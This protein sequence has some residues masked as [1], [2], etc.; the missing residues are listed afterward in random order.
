[1]SYLAELPAERRTFAVGSFPELQINADDYLERPPGEEAIE[2]FALREIAVLGD[3]APAAIQQLYG[4]I[5][6]NKH[7]RIQ[8]RAKAIT[9]A[10]RTR[11]NME[12]Q[13]GLQSVGARERFRRDFLA[14]K[15]DASMKEFDAHMRVYAANA[16][17]AKVSDKVIMERTEKLR[18]YKNGI[19]ELQMVKSDLRAYLAEADRLYKKFSLYQGYGTVSS[20]AHSISNLFNIEDSR[21][22]DTLRKRVTLG[23]IMEIA[24]GAGVKAVDASKES[25]YVKD[26]VP[27]PETSLEDI[28]AY[29]KFALAHIERQEREFQNS[30]MDIDPNSAP[31]VLGAASAP[32]AIY[33]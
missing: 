21:S 33:D 5:Q 7:E 16:K 6:R 20:T 26:S 30:I 32:S 24:K 28:E 14:K 13:F 10:M 1:M 18:G 25:K 11:Y 4:Q 19:S 2:Q 31:Y 23:R 22:F 29:V 12:S 27:G 15:H 3:K 9:G 17:R 8:A